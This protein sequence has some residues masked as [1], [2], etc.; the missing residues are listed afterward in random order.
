[1][2]RV[3]LG[4]TT[5][6]LALIAMLGFTSPAV[7]DD[8]APITT[9]QI[10][11]NVAEDGVTHVE[12][13]FEMDF[14][15]VRGRGP[16]FELPL[17][18]STGNTDEYVLFDI[19]NVEVTSP[20]GAR[21]DLQESENNGSLRLRIGDPDTFYDTPQTYTISFDVTGLVAR[22]REEQGTGQTTGL[23]EFSWN[24]I[25]QMASRIDDL[26]VTVTGPAEVQRAEG[27]TGANLETPVEATTSGNT[28][29]YEFG[30]VPPG[31][32]AQVVAGYPLNTFTDVEQDIQKPVPVFGMDPLQ[33]GTSGVLTLGALV[34]LFMIHRRHTRDEVYLG[35]TPGL[36]PAKGQQG[37]VGRASRKFKPTVQ[38]HPPKGARPGEIGTLTDTT[39]DAIDVSATIIDLA[40]RGHITI[41]PLEERGEN[42]L[43]TLNHGV[44]DE[45]VHHEQKLLQRLFATG[46][47][48]TTRDLRDE[49]YAKL[50]SRSQD[51]LYDRVVKLGWFKTRPAAAQATP[52]MLGMLALLLAVGAVFVLGSFSWGLLAVPLAVFGL[53][54]LLISKGFRTRTA[55]GSAM[56]AQ[57][58]GFE[59]YLRTAEADQ[60]KF[61]EGIDVFSRYLPYAMI[62]GVT[63]R[64]AKVFQQLGAEGRYQ[65]DLSWYGGMS[66]YDAFLFSHMINSFS[67]GM[68]DAFSQA[69]TAAMQ[70]AAQSMSSS[71]SGFSGFGGGGGFSGG[72][73]SGGSW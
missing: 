55:R 1:M 56:L 69:S 14:S 53:G 54:M 73:F 60:I 45:L 20:S 10:D 47:E 13:T 27:Y 50:Q 42:N 67:Y 68:N 64:W 32:S 43:M 11:A 44:R 6:L 16:Q 24:A 3:R 58:K 9:W 22:D 28:A 52:V 63:E 70:S 7:A 26:T 37:A 59:L 66:L 61:E 72:G 46:D 48:I 34:S 8:S 23:D 35:L 38:F 39:A 49:R 51:D 33:V 40:V 19:D 21:T 25:G 17:R 65:T 5:L 15:E 57:A 4:L 41:T 71:S 29:T 30:S 31:T 36:T 2:R 12:S 18:Q 62:F